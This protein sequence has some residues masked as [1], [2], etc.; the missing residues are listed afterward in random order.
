VRA[1]LLR[2]PARHRLEQPQLERLLSRLRHRAL[3]VARAGPL[4]G[5]GD[6]RRRAGQAARAG[7]DHDD[8]GLELAAV[9]WPRWDEREHAIADQRGDRR[10][11]R[12]ARHADRDNADRARVE[13][14]GRHVQADL[15]AVEGAGRGRADGVA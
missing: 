4:G 12:A 7:G 1:F 9:A 13:R 14:A 2:Q 3:D 8:A 15:R 6:H 10:L 5:Q 11:R